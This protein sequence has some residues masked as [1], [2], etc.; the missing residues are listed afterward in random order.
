MDVQLTE[1]YRDKVILIIGAAGSVGSELIKQLIDL[2]PK[3]IRAV[4]NNE[5]EIFLLGEQ[6]RQGC[7]FRAYLGDIRDFNKIE[8]LCNKVDIVFHVAAYKHVLL[9]EYNPFETVQT[10][11]LGVKNVIQAAV[12]KYVPRVIFTSSDKAVNPTSVMGT[13]KLMGERLVT[14]ANIVNFNG[15][16]IF[17]SVRFGNVIGS[18]G[19]VVPIFMKQIE[20]GGPV[21]VTEEKMTRFFMT[22][23][24]AARLVLEAGIYS[25][26]G[27]VF[28]TKMPVMRIIDLARAMIDILAPVYG[29]HPSSIPIKFIGAKSG[30]K[31]YEELMTAEE[32]NRA[33]E[34]RNMFAILPALRSFYHNIRYE[35]ADQ[36]NSRNINRP[37]N[38]STETPMGLDGIKA[39]LLKHDILEVSKILPAKPGFDNVA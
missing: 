7:N 23:P 18:R 11:I 13:T 29:Y 14:S 37:Y 9:S 4:D 20:H 25:C 19:S 36:L 15:H 17:S 39:F 1:F 6:Y 31:L 10:N 35:Y 2:K 26:G 38:S 21:T 33:L 12:S 27:E 28:V 22:L 32:M 30:E 16:Q 8:K 24:E 3:E 5:T 34:L